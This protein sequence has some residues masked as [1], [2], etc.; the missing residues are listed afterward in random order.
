MTT[1][2]LNFPTSIFEEI[3]AEVLVKEY[4]DM[5]FAEI[6]PVNPVSPTIESL[7]N[8]TVDYTGKAGRVT[9]K[10]GE[11][12][13]TVGFT[14]E[15]DSSKVFDFGFAVPIDLED[16]RAAESQS[17][18][19]PI[20]V[21]MDAAMFVYRKSLYDVAMTGGDI[22]GLAGLANLPEGT[23]NNQIRTA[24]A[25][26]G[27]WNAS[28][29]TASQIADDLLLGYN[30]ALTQTDN[31]R[32]PDTLVMPLTAFTIANSKRLDGGLGLSAMQ[33]F[34]NGVRDS[35]GGE[36]T[37]RTNLAFKT[38]MLFYQFSTD[39]LRMNMAQSIQFHDQQD[40]GLGYIVPVHYRFS[41]V[42]VRNFPAFAK[43][44]DIL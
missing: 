6:V 33:I 4:G 14:A 32:K 30:N 19:D 34:L 2:K 27:K 13:N 12:L 8:L 28:G 43:V 24:N 29:K 3:E 39:V 22:D 35:G 20:Q 18:I 9:G 11:K 16:I 44:K 17:N 42:Q 25:I 21:K 15:K 10:Y 41:G 5:N 38:D 37:V 31:A 40:E 7:G 26:G 1:R 36:V 23:G